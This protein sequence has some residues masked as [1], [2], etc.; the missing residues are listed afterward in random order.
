MS[1]C[2]PE[3]QRTCVCWCTTLNVDQRKSFWLFF[4]INP[5]ED[6]ARSTL[7]DSLGIFNAIS[8]TPTSANPPGSSSILWAGR[9]TAGWCRLRYRWLHKLAA[10]QEE[11]FKHGKPREAIVHRCWFFTRREL[12]AQMFFIIVLC[13]FPV[14]TS[15]S[16]VDFHSLRTVTHFQVYPLV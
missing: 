2:V 8:G 11:T 1:I 15:V 16:A 14:E 13:S 12:E 10:S 6:G 5:V 4:Q 7:S 3:L 9:F